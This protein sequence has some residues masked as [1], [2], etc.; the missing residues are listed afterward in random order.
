MYLYE[1]TI[2]VAG[3]PVKL[4]LPED[5]DVI[6]NMYSALGRPD[7]DP[8]WATLWQG[9]VA[10]AEEVLSKPE[11]VAGKRVIDLGTGLG[12]AGIA[13][14]L[15]GAKEVVMTDREPRALYCT[16][17]AAA[18]NGLNIAPLPDNVVAPDEDG[19]PLP[20][21]VLPVFFGTGPPPTGPTGTASVALLDWFEPD[22]APFGGE[23]FDVVLACDVLYT[24]EA[25]DVIAPL[26]VNLFEGGRDERT[27]D[28]EKEGNKGGKNGN[29]EETE[30]SPSSPSVA[31][32]EAGAGGGGLF[33]LADP[34]GRFPLNHAKFLKLMEDPSLMIV[35]GRAR[36][37][38]KEEEEDDDADA[39]AS[40]M[41]VQVDK[42]FRDC[43]NLEGKTMTVELS[44]YQISPPRLSV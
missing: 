16:L 43:V 36:A 22:F 41:V 14:G 2:D 26:V 17:C 3:T 35:E 21:E 7:V 1:T 30:S 25:V 4:V 15:A 20:S 33:V 10:L 9:S 24:P 31:E 29:G 12:L 27:D 28:G 6:V 8:H 13:A 44:S 38:G 19:I 40:M 34:P 11:L 23:G 37:E 18:A 39:D 32:L 42:Q 5:E